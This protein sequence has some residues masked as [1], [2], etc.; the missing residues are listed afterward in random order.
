MR[1]VAVLAAAWKLVVR[2][3][4]GC[5]TLD[6]VAGLEDGLLDVLWLDL[7]VVVRRLEFLR[8]LVP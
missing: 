8:V 4:L 6:V 2:C 3:L 7:R 5:C 1:H